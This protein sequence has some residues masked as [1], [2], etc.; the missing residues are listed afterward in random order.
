MGVPYYFEN[1]IGTIPLSELDAN[2]A[3]LEST[4]NI[5]YTAPFTNAVQETLTAKLAQTVSVKDFGAKGDGTTDDTTAIQNAIN[6]V[7]PTLPSS[8]GAGS[9]YF[10]PGNY[11]IT[12]TLNCTN[13]RVTGTLSRDGLMMYGDGIGSN[14][15]GQTGTG[16]AIIETTGSQWLTIRDINLSASATTPATVGIYQGV[17]A[18]LLQTQNQ[19]FEKVTIGLSDS[20]TA[21]NN[22]GTIGIW[23]QGAEENTY[24]TCYVTANVPYVF[25]AYATSPNTGIAYAHSYQSPLVASHSCGVNTLIGENFLVSLNARTA[26]LITEDVNSLS[27]SNCYMSNIGSGGSSNSAWLVYGS[28][29]G[30]N[31]SGTIE[32]Y[33]TALNVYGQLSAAELR[34]TFGGLIDSTSARV[35]LQRGGSGTIINSNISFYDNVSPARAL[36]SA[37]PLAANELIS[38][39][40]SNTTFKTN[41]DKQY[42]TIQENVKWN[43]YSGNIT[44]FGLQNTYQPYKYEIGYKQDKVDLP[45]K[46]CLINGGITS[47]EV[48]R[49]NMPTV[50]GSANA[51]S[52]AVR[53]KGM[54]SI[55]GTGTNSNSTKY[56]DTLIDIASNNTG[57]ISIAASTADQLAT[58]TTANTNASGNNITAGAVNVSTTS[59]Y[60]SLSVAPTR[61][62]VNLENVQFLGSAEMFWNGNESRSPSM[63]VI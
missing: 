39:F 16:Y 14:I 26:C 29:T 17:S 33:G 5:N 9:V 47:A 45:P 36:M 20:S 51:T 4:T 48:V 15:I 11:L 21:N 42:L 22:R 62:G 43:Q 55:V 28:L 40:I 56:I 34:F 8:L 1:Q 58:T 3:A 63:Q 2:F 32:Q 60:I 23:N 59:N 46:T 7:C 53:L 27:L 24:D 30:T 10:P 13:S 61:T 41:A 54:L 18:A 44:I 38:C 31:G 35:I 49:V 6:A 52:V 25:T 12:S 37:T 50:T 19:K 57:T